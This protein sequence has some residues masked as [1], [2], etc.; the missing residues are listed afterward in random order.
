MRVWKIIAWSIVGVI[1]MTAFVGGYF[2]S[3]L[4]RPV[5]L[6]QDAE[7][8]EIIIGAKMTVVDAVEQ[9]DAKN[10]IQSPVAAALLA[11]AYARVTG[12]GVQRGVYEVK[13]GMRQID[14]VLLFFSKANVQT[15]TVTFQ[16]GLSLRRYAALAAEKIKCNEAEFLRLAYSDSLRNARNITAPSVEGYLMPNTYAFYKRSTAVEILD[17]LLDEQDEFWEKECAAKA[18]EREITRQEVLTLA[19]IVEAETPVDSEKKRVSGVYTNRLKMGMKLEADPTVQYALDRSNPKRTSRRVLYRDLTLD[20]PYNTYK[21]FG[22]PPT[23]I[24]SP[25]KAAIAAAVSP[26]LHK[27]YYFVAAMDGS[28]THVFSRTGEEH[29]KAVALFRARRARA[30]KA[31]TTKTAK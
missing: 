21:N 8:V 25:G 15:V 9:L 30:V 7:T 22:L 4:T 19:S 11:R 26:E 29:Q 20:S 10:L 5:N 27:F 17:K 14:A 24:N 2:A 3:Q 13:P 12:R 6:A 31:T 16:E 28:N 18:K 1:V 23:P